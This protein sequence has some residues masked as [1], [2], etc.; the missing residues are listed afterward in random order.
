ME[1]G[2]VK[3]A[4]D[5]LLSKAPRVREHGRMLGTLE[6]TSPHYNREILY[7]VAVFVMYARSRC[8]DPVLV[9]AVCRWFGLQDV[10]IKVWESIKGM[11]VSSEDRV[12]PV[13]DRIGDEE[14]VDLFLWLRYDSILL[15]LQS[16]AVLRLHLEVLLWR[17]I[18]NCLY[19]T[20]FVA[21][22]FA[23]VP[24]PHARSCPFCAQADDAALP[25]GPDQPPRGHQAHV[26]HV[27]VRGA[28]ERARLRP[29][30]AQGPR[31]GR[32][33]EEPLAQPAAGRNG[34]L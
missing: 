8:S 31:Q 22:V 33:R 28:H 29:A 21:H 2:H 19:P 9:S 5:I 15:L 34:I 20:S 11:S 24:F 14:C 18:T 7:L 23:I 27:A 13:P 10:A 26:H 32:G 1:L 6:T 3:N 16:T 17:M 25:P 4:T 12:P 30:E